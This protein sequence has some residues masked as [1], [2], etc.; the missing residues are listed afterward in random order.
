MEK[1]AQVL[2]TDKR[3]KAPASY[4]SVLSNISNLLSLARQTA[5]RSVN[6]MM[7]ATYWEIG[8]YIT[9]FEQ[10]GKKRA[11][12]AEGLLARLSQ[13]LTKL[14]GRGFSVDRLGKMRLFY[15]IYRSNN[16]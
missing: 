5:A 12:Y 9:E 7:T 11:E 15:Q 2:T 3:Q 16:S 13:D 10:H 8:R 4:T 14:F 1:H 6:S